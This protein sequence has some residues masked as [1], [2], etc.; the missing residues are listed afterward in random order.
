MADEVSAKVSCS[1][2]DP[3][4]LLRPQS[5]PHQSDHS[6]ISSL[7]SLAQE[8]IAS[9]SGSSCAEEQDFLL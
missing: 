2:G 3:D 9:A 5:C 7:Q 8:A 6:A 1:C 4:L